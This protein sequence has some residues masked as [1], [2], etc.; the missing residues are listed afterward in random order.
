MID[1]ATIMKRI[2]AGEYLL[3]DELVL[4]YRDRLLRFAWSKY[5]SISAAE[6][7]VQEAFLAA[8][9]ARDS[10][11]P[12]FAFS[13]WLWTI[14]LNLCRRHYKREL[15]QPREMVRSSFAAADLAEIPEPSSSETPLQAALK[16]EQF[17]LLAV[18]LSELSEVQ[19]D[20]LRLRFF[21]G[22]KFSEIALTM[23][24]SLSAAKIRVKNGLLKLAHRFS[25]DKTSEGDVS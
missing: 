18:Y 9:A 16:T 23:D 7:L 21:G 1:D 11:N 20:A 2:C 6:D 10:Y 13:T 19:A 15:R 5:G 8:F 3:F 14:F 24:C 17:E 4:R 22:M 25:E 12:E